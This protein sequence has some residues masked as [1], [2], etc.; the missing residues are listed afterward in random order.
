MRWLKSLFSRDRRYDE[1]SES[2]REHLDEKIADLMDR[3]MTREDAERTARREFGNVTRIEER[4]REVWQW[5]TLEG[6]IRDAHHA[7]RSLAKAPAFASTAVLTLALGI[8]A[9]TAIFTLVHAVLLRSLPVENPAELWRVGDNEQCCFGSGL[10]GSYSTPNDW[11]LFSYEQYREFHEH[12]PGFDSLAAFAALPDQLAVR[13]T[14]SGEQVEPYSGEWVSGNAFDTL[15]LQAYAGRLLHTSDDVKGA[16][17]VAVMS[18]PTWEQK[19]GSDPTVV[20]RSLSVNGQPVIVVG[21]APPNFY[22]ERLSPTPP[23]FW[24][25]LTALSVLSPADNNLDHPDVQWLNLIGR[26]ASGASIAGIQARMQV[27]LQ[28][29]LRSPLSG[30]TGP[31][32]VLITK[33]YLRLTPG[34]GGVQRMQE[35]YR[36]NLH[37]LMWI[38]G[39]VLLIACANL[40]NLMLA[41]SV[42]QRQQISVRTAL[43]APRRRLVQLALV[44]CL[45]LSMLGGLAGLL[46]AWGG[47]KLILHMAFHENP[48][49]IS[50]SP[51]LPVLGFAFGASLLTGLLFGVAPAWM[52]AHANPIEALR[53][54]NRATSHSTIWTQKTLVV[55]QAAV[56][57]VLLCAAG[58]LILSLN[59]LQHQHYGFQTAY[60]TVLMVDPQDAGY[61][62]NQLDAFY[63]QLHDTLG[64]IPGVSKVAWSLWSPMDGRNRSLQIYVEGQP[65][66]PPGSQENY[67]SWNRISPGYFDAIGTRLIGG[68]SILESDGRTGRNVAVVNESFV[69][70]ILHGKNPIGIH[71]GDFDPSFTRTYEIVGVVEDAQYWNP[72]S[73]IRPMYF[74]P[75]AQWPQLPT[76]APQSAGYEQLI[77]N[78][79][80]MWS[81]ELETHGTVPGLEAQ[82]R[83][84]LAEVNPNLMMVRYQSFA[85]QM[86]SAFSQQNMIVQLTSL[87]GALALVLATIGLYGVMAYEVAQRTSEIGIRMALGANRGNVQRLMLRGAFLQ[88]GLGMLIGIPAA[89]LAGHLMASQLFGVTNYSPLVLGATILALTTTALAAAVVPA[90]RAASIDPM[91]TLRGE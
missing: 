73:P 37:L 78:T 38:S 19:F 1:L 32:R 21:I 67:V 82:V 52:A 54:A 74:V 72:N 46:F 25:P 2:I 22:G 89:I 33:Q 62:P 59:R 86:S 4:S 91:Q 81:I 29:F 40:A 83:R 61:Q 56:S 71:F 36:A 80:Y 15:G 75:A 68:R 28:Q 63:Q 35:E 27:E 3:G 13:R 9:T 24:L 8:G 11:S 41:R 30:I 65:P 44:E 18:Y 50:A 7:F 87:F 45:L 6:I 90:R 43:G 42:T 20:G 76:S 60:R 16:V 70:N 31:M 17:P 10:P 34:G 66:P 79:H 39:F 51:S 64:A 55:A 5:Q 57:V 26:I 49:N 69:R 85:E 77:A 47:A 48:V 58:F 12:T 84:A 14:G 88:V 23:S 53:G